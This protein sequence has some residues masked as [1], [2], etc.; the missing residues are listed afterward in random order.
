MYII[1]PY[2][3]NTSSLKGENSDQANSI[4]SK[5]P[6]ILIPSYL[7]LAFQCQPINRLAQLQKKERKKISQPMHPSQCPKPQKSIKPN[8]S[9][10]QGGNVSMSSLSHNCTENQSP[11]HP[12]ENQEVSSIR[13]N[14]NP[15]PMPMLHAS[16]A[17]PFRLTYTVSRSIIPSFFEFLSSKLPCHVHACANNNQ[18]SRPA[19]GFHV[20]AATSELGS[21]GSGGAVARGS[22]GTAGP[23]GARRAGHGGVE[24]SGI[25]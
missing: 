8:P 2:Y 13:S 14:A 18:S 3:L 20:A 5:H 24:D 6:F 1:H 11:K 21:G 23:V 17:F 16:S 15:M 22:V 10:A 4:P 19:S 25:G 12:V 9:P 7:I